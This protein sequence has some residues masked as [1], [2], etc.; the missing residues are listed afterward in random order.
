VRSLCLKV[1]KGKGEQ[2]RKKLL[3]GDLLDVSLKVR[4][5]GG[6][7]LFPVTSEAAS[8][9]G[10]Q[11]DE[12]E[13]E[14]R[15]LAASDYKGLVDVP[16]DLRPLLPA[17]FDVV[18][19]VAII[20]VPDELLPYKERIGTALRKAFPRFTTVALD[21]GVKGELRVRDLE[22]IAGG[23]GT[24]TLHM[25]YGIKLLVDPSRTYF[26]PRLSNERFRV[27]KLVKEGEVVIDMFAGVGPFSIMIAKH[28][29]PKV[30]YA[31]DLNRD[32]VEYLRRNVELNRALS[33]KPI[34]GDAREEIG[35]LP[36]ADRII[37]NL[38]HSAR[39]FLGDALMH[40]RPQGTIHLY[41]IC[42]RGDIEGLSESIIDEADGL[43][44]KISLAR[45]EE[46]KTY[47]P[48]MSVY[49]LDLLLL[50]RS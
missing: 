41:Q 48:S 40:L 12:E 34:Q 23:P 24:E 5:E 31:I 44:Y 19:E 1:P 50:E 20:K 45:L 25:E 13:F 43:G 42:D 4:R 32:A 28:S 10:Y 3:E 37:M 49:A 35:K 38:P 47:S 2:V 33:V 21:K 18:G 14:Q 27:A 8:R 39:E 29:S 16:E 9:L 15:E 30:V 26:N 17:S 6:L 36:Q 22:V 46:L 11:M 7:I